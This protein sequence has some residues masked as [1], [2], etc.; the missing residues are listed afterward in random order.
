MNQGQIS[1]RAP[2]VSLGLFADAHYAEMVYGDRHCEES[3]AKL[4]ACIDT[5]EQGELDFVV[6]MGD[7]IDKSE[8]HDVELGYLVRM[9]EIFAGFSGPRHF[10]IGNHD[11]AALTK[12]E[13]LRE[14]G[15]THPAYYSFDVGDVHFAVLDGNCHRDGSDF[16]AGNF[17]WDD[18]W[19]SAAQ[20]EWLAQD[21]A[22]SSDR[23]SI[24]FCHEN[25][26]HR[27]W[28]G[29]LD[30]HILRNADQVRGVLETAGN[31]RAVIQA[32]YHPG[33]QTTMNGIDYL[34]L[35][36]MVVGAGLENNSFA[37]VSVHADGRLVLRGF[38][39]QPNV[40][41]QLREDR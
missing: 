9:R 8:D 32:H 12:D 22:E 7:I 34:G 11:V 40:E 39:Q 24:V 31:V 14:C 5:F 16:S 21:L 26:D 27:L 17:A 37:I 25:L 19:V 23:K 29:E 1:R 4:A 6:C 30:P 33:L 38:E 10:V 20:L 2:V 13:F 3:P 41:L 28:N 35:R 18:A 15:A 36:A